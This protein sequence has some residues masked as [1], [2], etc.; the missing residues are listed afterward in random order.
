MRV[1][2]A[3]CF[4]ITLTIAVVGRA[5][6][7]SP[8]GLW[9]TFDDT[10]KTA[11]AL[12]RITEQNGALQGK[13]EK[14]ILPQGVDQNPVCLKC[15]GEHQGQTMIGMAIVSNLKRDKDEYRGG[16]IYDPE[17]GETYQCIIKLVDS[18]RKMSVRGYIGIPMLGRSQIWQRE[19]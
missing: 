9:K 5:D 16:T 18:G 3:I 10:G 19:E 11:K 13:I 8:V 1:M 14:L 6:N 12:V 4:A 15:K 7:S 17:V 2:H